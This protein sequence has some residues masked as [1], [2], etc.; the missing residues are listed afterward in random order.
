MTDN[1]QPDSVRIITSSDILLHD[2]ETALM[3]EELRAAIDGGHESM[4]HA[5]A[6]AEIAAIRAEN[7]ALQQSYDA[8]R[9]EID[10]LRDATK[11]MEPV[12]EYPAI[13][14][15]FINKHVHPSQAAKLCRAGWSGKDESS[16]ETVHPE[17]IKL[18]HAYV[19]ADRAMRAKATSAT[20]SYVQ[21]V[22][23]KC[24]RITWRGGYYHLPP[25]AQEADSVT[26]P[27]SGKVAGWLPVHS[28]G[29][30]FYGAPLK[31]EAEAKQYINQV[32]QSSDSV[33]LIARPF[34]WIATPPAQA[35]DSMPKASFEQKDQ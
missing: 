10:H 17:V 25:A 18:L 11:M 32:H 2:A 6:L 16:V 24:D 3:Y 27:A 26:A 8:A 20:D 12:G 28:N 35:A 33:T 29:H 1:T 13:T 30:K 15:E 22:P 34:T 19:D 21:P 14:A 31:T 9:M 4:T 5:D 7:A 23:D